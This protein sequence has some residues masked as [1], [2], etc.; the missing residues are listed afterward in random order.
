MNL[1]DF[2]DW[3]H[4]VADIC[5]IIAL[6]VILLDKHAQEKNLWLK[7]A[8]FLSKNRFFCIPEVIVEVKEP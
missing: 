5:G 4:F 1:K 6:I 3:V 8:R 2:F 7:I